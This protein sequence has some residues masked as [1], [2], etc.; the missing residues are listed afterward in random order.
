ML[1]YYGIDLLLAFL[2]NGVDLRDS[3]YIR[4]SNYYFGNVEHVSKQYLAFSFNQNFIMLYHFLNE[5]LYKHM[6]TAA[7]FYN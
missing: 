1:H 4:V 5:K 6:T 7:M 2:F 3:S